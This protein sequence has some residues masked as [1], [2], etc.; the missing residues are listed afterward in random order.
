MLRHDM[1][2]ILVDITLLVSRADGKHFYVECIVLY[3]TVWVTND[4]WIAWVDFFLCHA[5]AK[6]AKFTNSF[7]TREEDVLYL[8]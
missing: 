2:V 4:V 8:C 5:N 1:I 6:R 3:G 7:R